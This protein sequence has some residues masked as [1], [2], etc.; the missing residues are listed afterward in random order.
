M[1][2]DV[3][4]GS[5]LVR[6]VQIQRRAQELRPISNHSGDGRKVFLSGDNVA[7]RQRALEL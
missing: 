2:D 6:P 1:E 5:T 7:R 3:D 4:T